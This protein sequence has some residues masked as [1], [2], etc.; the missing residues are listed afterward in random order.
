MMLDVKLNFKSFRNPIFDKDAKESGLLV[1]VL[2]DE[3]LFAIS[4]LVV[5]DEVGS[6]L[7]VCNSIADAS[8]ES[9]GLSGLAHLMK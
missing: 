8:K 9:E 2:T 6:E 3:W 4:V 5:L 1:G 7:S